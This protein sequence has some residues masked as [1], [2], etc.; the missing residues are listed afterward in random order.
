MANSLSNIMD[1][2]LARGLMVLRETAVMPRLVSIDYANDA[3]EFGDTIDIP[4][5]KSQTVSAVTSGV[6]GSNTPASKTPGKVQISMDQWRTTDFHM[7]DKDMVEVDRNRHFVPGQTEEA[8]RALANDLDTKIHAKYTGIYGWVGTGGT[9]PFSTVATATD[10]RK[11]LNSQL[12]PMNDRRIVMDPTAESQA[13]Q[14]TAY[15]DISQS[16]DR[17]V[18]IDGEVGRKF[19]MDHFMS[20]NVTSHSKGT[21]T[22]AVIASTTAAGA[23]TVQIKGTSTIG[24]IVVGDV[25]TIAGNDQTYV[26]KT[27]GT[28]VSTAAGLAVS[29][30]PGLAAIATAAAAV[31]IKASHVVNLA[32]QRNAFAYVTRPLAGSAIET[33]Q[34][35]AIRS[36]SDNMTGLTMRLEVVRQRKQ[37]AWEFD[38]LHGEALVRP[39]LAARIAG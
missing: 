38:I 34:G 22:T 6:Q 20:Q 15:S 12:A 13:L 16:D 19:G 23:S 17:A 14:L 27:A 4:K 39:E 29:I 3:R 9:T 35:T 18:K 11:V 21:A 26:S 30:S 25:F 33:G 10:A 1:K 37:T 7:S 8:A 36:M 28:L 24:T 2:I 31:T 32:F 5:T